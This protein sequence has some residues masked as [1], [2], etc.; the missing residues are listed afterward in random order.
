MRPL[1]YRSVGCITQG[2]SEATLWVVIIGFGAVTLDFFS[3]FLSSATVKR[4]RP[5]AQ[6]LLLIY[7]VWAGGRTLIFFN[8]KNQSGF[9]LFCG[10]I[11]ILHVT[12]S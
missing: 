6:R 12:I 8:R 11:V 5:Q 9:C 3:F 4:K 10:F 1:R 7:N 2:Y